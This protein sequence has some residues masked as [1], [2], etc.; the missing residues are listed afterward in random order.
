MCCF[1]DTYCICIMC[2]MSLLTCECSYGSSSALDE[3]QQWAPFPWPLFSH[4]A[5]AML[6][7]LCNYL[8]WVRSSRL[9]SCVIWYMV[10]NFRRRLQPPSSGWKVFLPWRCVQWVKVKLSP[11][12]ASIEGMWRSGGVA[13]RVLS[14]GTRWWWIMCLWPSRFIPEG[15][16]FQTN[17]TGSLVGLRIAPDT[18]EGRNICFPCRESNHDFSIVQ[19]VT[20]SL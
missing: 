8:E 13:P 2:T 5:L 4:M 16:A 18:L 20:L 7:A 9:W 11:C 12:I 14:L 1:I 17:W 3:C 19:P 15:V 10:T 6:T